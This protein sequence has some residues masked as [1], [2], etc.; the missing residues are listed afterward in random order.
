MYKVV[1][2]TIVRN[3]GGDRV[4]YQPGDKIEPTEAEL[5]HFGDNLSLIEPEGSDGEDTEVEADSD[6][7]ISIC[8]TEMSD[9]STCE[10]PADECGYH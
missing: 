5:E 7:D 1:R 4:K 9:G 2:T 8:G 10:R 6:L 3:E